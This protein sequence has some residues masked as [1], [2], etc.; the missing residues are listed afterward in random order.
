MDITKALDDKLHAILDSCHKQTGFANCFNKEGKTFFIETPESGIH[1]YSIGGDIF[2]FN[3]G[4]KVG[5][6]S[7]STKDLKT[8]KVKGL[9]ESL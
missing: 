8:F 4:K 5:E 1:T 7:I 2:S 9:P 6:W 3:T